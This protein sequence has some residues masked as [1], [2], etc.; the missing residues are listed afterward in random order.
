MTVGSRGNML[1]GHGHTKQQSTSIG[2]REAMRLG[3]SY[4]AIAALA[5]ATAFAAIGK[6]AP[7]P[8]GFSAAKLRQID[9][10]VQAMVDKGAIP[11]AVTLTYRHGVVAHCSTNGW[12]D[13]DAHTTMRRDT[14]FQIMSMTKPITAASILSLVDDGLIDLY[15]PVEKYLPELAGRR[16]LRTSSSPLDDTV[17]AERPMRI[18]DLLTFRSGLLNVAGPFNPNAGPL[19]EATAEIYARYVDDPDGWVKSIG[20]LPLGFQPGTA[21]SYG[22]SSEALSV[23]ASRVAKMPFADVLQQRIFGPLGMKD[24]GYFVPPAKRARLATVYR[25]EGEARKLTVLTDSLGLPQPF[26]YPS[27]PTPFPKGAYAL[28]STAD[29]YLQFARMLLQKGEVGGTRVLSHRAVAL[30]TSN[31]LPPEQRAAIPM[32]PMFKGQGWG[33]GLAVVTDPALQDE[34]LGFASAGS[35]GWPGAYGTWWQADP[36]EDMIQVYMHQVLGGSGPEVA[37]D[38]FHRLGY[39]AI[40]D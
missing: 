39:D 5:P 38:Q 19:A 2:R 9:P 32:G 17:P 12:Q 11:G 26:P 29:D 33:L 25:R 34:G 36:K 27:A 8:G 23:L 13:L 18:A 35:F 7:G 24:T 30:M 4:G 15:D 21:W 1:N 14:I 3:L 40:A 10:A 6:P 20:A 22:T 37:R 16:V 31:Y 28:S